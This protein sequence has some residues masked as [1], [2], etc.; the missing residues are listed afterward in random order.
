MLFSS[1]FGVRSSL[2]T[3]YF[4]PWEDVEIHEENGPRVERAHLLEF[5]QRTL[6]GEV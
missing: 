1:L 5:V 3:R 6:R 4:W 2:T